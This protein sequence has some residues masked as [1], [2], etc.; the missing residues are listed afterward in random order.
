MNLPFHSKSSSAG[1][2]L[3]IV[4][5]HGRHTKG[6]HFL[7]PSW[8]IP[9]SREL[10]VWWPE[11][12]MTISTYVLDLSPFWAWLYVIVQVWEIDVHTMASDYEDDQYNK[13][14]IDSGTFH[15][16]FMTD[17]TSLN[18]KKLGQTSCSTRYR[19]SLQS[20][21]SAPF[22]PVENIANRLLCGCANVS[23]NSAHIQD[24]YVYKQLKYQLNEFHTVA[25]WRG[26]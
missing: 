2:H 12:V 21:V 5:H 6:S 25:Y 3:L 24:W 15:G 20:Q 18:I 10:P 19:S 9:L 14:C 22:L 17:L 8:N 26:H 11:E 16:W 13:G 4:L 7:R 23:D 1:P